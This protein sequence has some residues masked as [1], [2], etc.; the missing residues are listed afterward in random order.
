MSKFCVSFPAK[1]KMFA[2]IDFD[3]LYIYIYMFE[4][5]S[6]FISI[7]RSM[8]L[9]LSCDMVQERENLGHTFLNRNAFSYYACT[10]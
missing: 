4:S 6:F 1:K 3:S 10:C 5:L 7:I 9:F 8:E 2:L